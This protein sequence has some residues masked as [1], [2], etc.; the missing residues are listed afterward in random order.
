MAACCAAHPDAFLGF[1]SVDPHKPDAVVELER[2]VRFLGLRGLK[3]HPGAQGFAPDDRAV[4]PIWETAQSLGIPCALGVAS[5]DNLTNKGLMRVQPERVCVWNAKQVEE[6]VEMHGV[7][8][9]HVQ[10][11]GA[12]LFDRWFEQRPS[13]TR[14]AF[15]AAHGFDPTRPIVLYTCSSSFIAP[16]AQE[17]AFVRSWLEDLRRDP[18]IGHV[19]VLVRPHPY[20]V[21]DWETADLTALGPVSIAPRRAYDPLADSVREGYFDA[22]YHSVAVVGVNTSAMIEAKVLPL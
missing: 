6:A 7:S 1:A 14:D 19:N 11:T 15:C 17:V 13:S 8:R 20:N 12:Q 16:A 9:D 22:L 5:W 21:W 2:A 4:Y 3:V 18:R 10:V